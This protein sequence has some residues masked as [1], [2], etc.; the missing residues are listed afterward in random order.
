MRLLAWEKIKTNE[1]KKASDK[2]IWAEYCS[3]PLDMKIIDFDTL[4]EMF[5]Q[6]EKKVQ[7]VAKN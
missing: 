7:G 1:L 6:P 5:A 2:N 4:E 3:S